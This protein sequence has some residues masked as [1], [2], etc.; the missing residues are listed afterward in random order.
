MFSG[1]DR[2]RAACAVSEAFPGLDQ[3]SRHHA[4]STHTLACEADD[5]RSTHGD[6]SAGEEVANWRDSLAAIGPPHL[7]RQ[8]C[9]HSTTCPPSACV[10]AA[11]TRPR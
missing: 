10:T 4:E 7:A 5:Q 6:V 1:L 3:G 2:E 8:I 9:D 11:R